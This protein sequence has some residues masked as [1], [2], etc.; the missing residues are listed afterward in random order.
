MNILLQD[1]RFAFRMLLKSP[2]FTAVAVLSLALGIGANTAIFSVVNAVLLKSLPYFDPDRIVLV[3]GD[4]RDTGNNRSQVSFTDTADWRKQNSSFEEIA[5]YTDWRPILSGVGEAERVPAMQ[6]GDG[7]FSVM[8]AEPLLGRVFTPE[9]QQ[10]G[11]DFVIILS[12]GLWQRR[13]GGDP[14]IIGQTTY[15]NSRPYTIVGVMPPGFQSLP[16]GLVEVPAELYR[17]VA[18]S[19]SEEDR[20]GRHLRAIARLRPG[21]SIDQAQAEMSTIA[22]RLEQEHPEHNASYGVRLVTLA[23]DTVGGLRPALLMLFGS[24]VFVLLIACANVGNLLLARSTTRQKEMAIRAALGAGR[25]RLVR[26]LLTESLM[27]SVVGGVGGLLVASWST[28]VITSL[29]S[30]ILPLLS[31]IDIDRRVL[32]FTIAISILTGIVFGIVPALAASRPDLNE[33]LKEGGRHSSSGSRSMRS[34]LVVVEIALALVLLIGAG[35]M[36]K[37]VVRLQNVDTGFN[38]AN[39]LTMNVWLPRAKYPD[40]PSWINFYNQAT[41]SIERVP[42]VKS[43][44]FV[45]ILPLASNFDGRG[46]QVE[47]RPVALGQ[48]PTVELY[49]ST[50]GYLKAMEIPVVK[51]RSIT[52]QDTID[53]PPVALINQTLADN[54]WPGEDPIGKRVRLAGSPSNPRPWAQVVGLLSDVKQKSVDAPPS[55]QIYLPQSQFPSSFLTL[56][57]RTEGEPQGMVAAVRDAVLAVD[58][59]Q[60]VFNIATM[61][62]LFSD[63]MALRRFSVL[64]LGLFSA[65]ALVLAAGGIY[66]VIS[67]SVTQRTHEIGIRM[68]LGARSRDILKLVVG[69]GIILSFAGVA[70]GLIAAFAVTRALSSLL[71]QTSATDAATFILIPLILISVA[72][73]ASFIPARRAAR[74][75]PMVAL[76]YE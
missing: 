7:Y 57:V 76:R 68:A 70:I 13:F 8:K 29:G 14:E 41:E 17:P 59:D 20:S 63:S 73:L 45:S 37:S 42:G 46:L 71:Y 25:L 65:V 48:E 52:E 33:S 16:E 6:V 35:L 43:A 21:V 9:E 40:A 54:M 49:I 19:Y 74:V 26:Q 1:A 31:Q 11:K 4:S 38:P 2:G 32:L 3:W 34:S 69:H 36:I 60:A 75:D 44:G 18:E 24:V 64:L 39:A 50:P 5:N 55:M 30:K 27:L 10:E 67:Y 62:Q 12:H 53:S 56:V 51:G 58:K 72:L 66:G 15:L 47:D 61:D 28:G 22:S 23:E